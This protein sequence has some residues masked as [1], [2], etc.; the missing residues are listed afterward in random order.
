MTDQPEHK[1]CQTYKTTF[2]RRQDPR[3]LTA[4]WMHRK[5]CSAACSRTRYSRNLGELT[6]PPAP[7]PAAR[8]A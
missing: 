2:S 6:K 1:V 5:F 4:R 8:R 3:E 7:A